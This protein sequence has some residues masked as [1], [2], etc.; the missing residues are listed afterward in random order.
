MMCGRRLAVAVRRPQWTRRC[1]LA[2][3]TNE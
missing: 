3:Y 2:L 1:L